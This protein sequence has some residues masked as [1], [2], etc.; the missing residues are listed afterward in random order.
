MWQHFILDLFLRIAHD[1]EQVLE[2]LSVE[3]IHCQPSP[4]SNSIAWLTWHLTRSYDR[5]ISELAGQEQLW[6]MEGWYTKFNRSPDPTE[7]GF[8]HSAEE[9]AAFWAPDSHL[10][11]AYH[12][13]VLERIRQYVL[14]MLSE[15][16]LDREVYSPTLQNTATVRRR[17][18]GII[19]EGFQH[20]GQAAY[21]RGLLTGHGWLER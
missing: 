1:L 8:G 14:S 20:V 13:A 5:N 7:T 10:L 12:R 4:D 15:E 18:V 19:S 6:I 3:E 11:L 9:A 16:D 2:G 21:R 17:L